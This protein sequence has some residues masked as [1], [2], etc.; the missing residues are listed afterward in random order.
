MKIFKK[1]INYKAIL[2]CFFLRKINNTIPHTPI[3]LVPNSK[4]RSY[5]GIS[6]IVVGVGDVKISKYAL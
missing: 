4:I 5:P 1:K 2:S 3:P 6:G